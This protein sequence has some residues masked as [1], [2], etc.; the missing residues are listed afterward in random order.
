M[1]IA[2]NDETGEVLSLSPDGQWQKAKTAV[3]PRTKEMMAY[4]GADWKTVPAKSKGILGYIDDAARSIAQ[5]VTFGYADEIGAAVNPA[6]NRA[7]GMDAPETY[8]A[9]LEQERARDAQIPGAI[10]YPGEIAGAV[11][12][13]VLAAPAVAAGAARAGLTALPKTAQFA[14]VG[15]AEGALMGSG[16]AEEGERLEGAATG[17]VVGAPVGAAAPHVAGGIAGLFNRIRGAFS[18]QRNV[19]ADLGRAIVRDKTTPEALGQAA[20]DVAQTRPGTA[21]LAD[22]GGENVRGLVER[23]AQTPGA[24]R[25][26]VVPR[27]TER[28]K[29]QASR[30]TKDL[31]TLTGTKR[32]AF[33]AQQ[34]V[35][36]ER[37]A[38][39][40]PLYEQAYEAGD[41]SIWSPELERL[42]GAA[43]VARAMRQAVSRW[44]TNAIADGYGAMKP[45]AMVENGNLR[46]QSGGP[47]AFPNIQ[48]WDYTKQALDDTIAATKNK[49]PSA[50]R[51]L[52]KIAQQLRQELDKAV[53][54]YAAA[55]DAWAGP[56]AYLDAIEEGRNILSRNMSSEEMRGA[57][58]ALTQAEKEA[59]R[60]GAISAVFSRI[61]NNAAKL[62]DITGV[63][64]S[65]EMRAKIA[66][67]MPSEEAANEWMKRLDFEVGSSE[68]TRQSLGN[69]ATARRLAERADAENVVVDLAID[70]LSG[71]GGASM[72]SRFLTAGPRWA[73]DTIR[74]RADAELGDLLTNPGRLKDL[75]GVLERAAQAQQP[76][77]GTD[78]KSVV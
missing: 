16:Q 78:R 54:E 6:I 44:Q 62:P 40:K 3:N 24:G 56:S 21:T 77:S 8:D 13:T 34:E 48:F 42:T 60:T 65:P 18:P 45:R 38:A 46:F 37:A 66:T 2:V 4:D 63:L 15:A 32:S 31:S 22:A 50:A 33:K 23:V 36:A 70:T 53:P 58:D 30:L 1:P 76:V 35:I 72:L 12:S 52:T 41:R 26:Q 69:S 25:T 61:G 27:L 7:L 64:R 14:G 43:P 75:Q 10:K 20:Q 47:P 68:L 11:G 51:A 5:G 29:N 73:R 28:Q 39:A 74:S 49:Q 59:F 67:I 9:A 17:A 71:P 19:A 55:R 57:F